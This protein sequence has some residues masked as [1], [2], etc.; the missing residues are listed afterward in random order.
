[1]RISKILAFILAVV[2]L[3][4]SVACSNQ[5]TPANNGDNSSE[6]NDT[7]N[8]DTSDTSDKKE[9]ENMSPP[10]TDKIVDLSTFI[11]SMSSS[12]YKLTDTVTEAKIGLS[13]SKNVG[14]DKDRFENEILYPVPADS[15]FAHIYKVSEHGIS[16]DNENNSL[17]LNA[18][19]KSLKNVEGLKKI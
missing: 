12:V 7:D 16:V 11:D 18:L 9:D 14:V 5:G 13:D 10:L 2:M 17:V 6:T 4:C 1:M 15:E 19:L 3:V 8:S